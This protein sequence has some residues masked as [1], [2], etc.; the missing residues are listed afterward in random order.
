MSVRGSP[1]GPADRCGLP[2]APFVWTFT[3]E[4]SQQWDALRCCATPS[5]WLTQ[6]FKKHTRRKCP[7]CWASAAA[8]AG[9]PGG[10]RT[11][12]M[13]ERAAAWGSGGGG[14]S[15]PS[16]LLRGALRHRWTTF[17]L[18]R[19]NSR[20]HSRCC[21]DACLIT[22]V[23]NSDGVLSG[24]LALLQWRAFHLHPLI[25]PRLNQLV[26]NR[27]LF[28][29]KF[30]KQTYISDQGR[31]QTHCRR[32]R[33]IV[34]FLTHGANKNGWTTFK[35]LRSLVASMKTVSEENHQHGSLAETKIT[36]C[37]DSTLL[38]WK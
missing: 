18:L 20:S 12:R 37:H 25:P 31:L 11:A 1:E 32:R 33:G 30:P 26:L 17:I 14:H 22:P 9:S 13:S 24:S 21:P 38:Q 23:E 35:K 29:Q 27:L 8:L 4:R 10:R 2:E 7:A 5:C 36:G 34:L 15:S 28:I 16:L 3:L 19:V 6:A